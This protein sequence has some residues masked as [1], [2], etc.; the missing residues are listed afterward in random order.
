L[1]AGHGPHHL[2]GV[3][4]VI[5]TLNGIPIGGDGPER[6]PLARCAGG[7]R[8]SADATRFFV[9]LV[10]VVM[11]FRVGDFTAMIAVIL[12][13]VVPAVRYTA[14]GVRDLNPRLIEASKALGTTGMQLLTKG[15]WMRRRLGL[16]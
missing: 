3:S 1:G 7:H 2:V 12:Y 10:P 16:G 6:P 11:L 8:Y 4:A 5:A 14:L 15:H 13:A 9:Y